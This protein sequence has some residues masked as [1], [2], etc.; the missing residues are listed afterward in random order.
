[1]MEGYLMIGGPGDGELIEPLHGDVPSPVYYY[2][3]P[4]KPMLG[5]RRGSDVDLT[6]PTS[7]ERYERH[8]LR[9]SGGRDLFVYLARGVDPDKVL[10]HLI[11]RYAAPRFPRR[12]SW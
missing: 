2:H 1:M 8:M 10:A 5:I 3:A 12:S 9:E 7:P 4:L 6:A 11:E